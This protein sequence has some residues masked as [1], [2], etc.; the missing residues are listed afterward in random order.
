MEKRKDTKRKA[1]NFLR[2]CFDV[3]NDIPKPLEMS[4][5]EKFLVAILNKQFLNEDP[6]DMGLIPNLAYNGQRYQIEKSVK[7]WETKT[8]NQLGQPS[9]DP[10]E[11]PDYDPNS[12]PSLPPSLDSTEDPSK[13]SESRYQD[14]TEDPYGQEQEEEQEQEEDEEEEQ[15]EEQDEEEAEVKVKMKEQVRRIKKVDDYNKFFEPN[16]C[17]QNLLDKK[18]T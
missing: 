11:D 4:D 16:E 1:F 5:G 13:S 9:L 3:Y 17:I 10:T 8:G 15:D 12:D 6:Q 7:G 14:P 18:L 2:S